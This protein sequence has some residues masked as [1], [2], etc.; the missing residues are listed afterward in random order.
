LSKYVGKTKYK[1]VATGQKE[2]TNELEG[3]LKTRYMHTV[4]E[5]FEKDK[6]TKLRVKEDS[7][8]TPI[9]IVEG[10]VIQITDFLVV[11]RT[12]SRKESFGFADFLQGRIKIIA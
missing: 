9:R 1:K 11:I 4:K 7:K 12:S 3:R 8:K 5:Q 6:R 10:T 2:S